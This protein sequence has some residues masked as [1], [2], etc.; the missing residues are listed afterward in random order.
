M[1]KKFLNLME[2]EGAEPLDVISRLDGDIEDYLRYLRMFVDGGDMA[3]LRC[4]VEAGDAEGAE[5]AVH[6]L[7]GV[8]LN[9][10]LLPFADVCIDMLGAYRSNNAHVADGML[11]EVEAEYNRWV[12]LV[13]ENLPA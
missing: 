7:K 3:A 11:D 13:E 2:D 12:R 1:P 8:A 5:H 6:T 9:L 4:A 10:G